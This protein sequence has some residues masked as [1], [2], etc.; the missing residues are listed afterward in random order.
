MNSWWETPLHSKF[1][2]GIGDVIDD[3]NIA[4]IYTPL[5]IPKSFLSQ[6]KIT[7]SKGE[8]ISFE[9]VNLLDCDV[10]EDKP[11]ESL[12]FNSFELDTNIEEFIPKTAAAIFEK[13]VL[14]ENDVLVFENLPTLLLDNF[15]G[16]I[17]DLGRYLS[18]KTIFDR[19]KIIV[20][21]DPNQ[22]KEN[23][24]ANESGIHKIY[25][26]GCYDKL[27]YTLGLRY[28]YNY[29][30]DN[31]TLLNENIIA[32]I[33][34]FD[35][36][37]IDELIEC[38]NLMED[39]PEILCDYAKENQ[40]GNIKFKELDKL[41]EVEVWDKWAKGIIEIKDDIKVYHSAF[42][43]IHNKDSELSKRVWVSGVA[44]MIPLIEEFRVKVLNCKYIFFPD[45]YSDTRTGD[46]KEDK[47]DLEIGEICYFINKN[48]IKL[49]GFSVLEKEN[50]KKYINLC[51]II[52]NDLSHLKMPVTSNVNLFI[53]NYESTSNLLMNFEK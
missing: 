34:S 8:H 7:L 16:F 3:G 41:T 29:N 18:R 19:Q 4:L 1:L 2:K 48:Y 42:L 33:S 36:K 44:V 13:I 11:I 20:T 12:L 43:K 17:I 6:L 27:D 50:L 32:S 9:K 39:Y 21:L 23:D 5:H 45:Y 52:R 37:L 40:W 49:R 24:F 38:N 15:K 30:A 53:V 10:E 47:M 31:F 51:R 35:I 14:D 22:F 26:Q 28:Y 46:V 25:F